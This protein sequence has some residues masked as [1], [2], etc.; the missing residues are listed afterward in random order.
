MTGAFHQLLDLL[1]S[2]SRNSPLG[3]ERKRVHARERVVFR[4]ESRNPKISRATFI[5]SGS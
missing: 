3:H 2:G 1:P 5:A 4:R